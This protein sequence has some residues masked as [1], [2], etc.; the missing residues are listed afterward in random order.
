MTIT[1]SNTG[2]L[3][4][5][6]LTHSSS[7]IIPFNFGDKLVRIVEQNGEPWFVAKDV[8]VAL[9]YQW[10]GAQRIEHVPS[11]WKGVTSVVTPGGMQEVSVLSE[12]GLYFFLGR[13]DK[14]AA[15]PFQKWIAGDVIPS[16]RKNGQ[17]TTQ[18]Q[19][20]NVDLILDTFR[21][22]VLPSVLMTMVDDLVTA[23]LQND[24]R[25]S[26]ESMISARQ[27]LDQEKVPSKGRR[28]LIV[29]ASHNLRDF[30]LQIGVTPKRCNRTK[31]WLFPVEII[32]RWLKL[33][34]RTLI[35]DHMSALYGQLKLNLVP[36]PDVKKEEVCQ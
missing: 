2:D 10:N 21:N 29:T 11:E 26:V 4:N 1:V 17:Y 14:A 7:S 35:A 20:F 28:S 3:N 8:A 24:P 15:L 32:N 27:I 13:S 16:I 19:A 25:I 33:V 23:K 9:G 36:M 31:T 6:V 34:G 12:Q 30:C 5:S 22:E 18:P